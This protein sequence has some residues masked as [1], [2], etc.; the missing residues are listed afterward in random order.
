MS[1]GAKVF[2]IVVAAGKK[3]SSVGI[4]AAES[5]VAHRMIGNGARREQTRVQERWKWWKSEEREQT[6]AVTTR[7][8]NNFFSKPSQVWLAGKPTHN[9]PWCWCFAQMFGTIFNVRKRR[10]KKDTDKPHDWKRGKRREA[11]KES[12]SYV[13][14]LF[15]IPKVFSTYSSSP[16]LCV[17]NVIW[18]CVV[19]DISPFYW[20]H[21]CICHSLI[22]IRK[23]L[24]LTLSIFNSLKGCNF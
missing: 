2:V 21:H 22:I 23:V 16:Q 7:C 9:E 8:R 14:R 20:H 13:S 5:T 6:L 19:F 3:V 24:I 4:R 17:R 1:E 10:E 11:R 15:L 12:A 18:C